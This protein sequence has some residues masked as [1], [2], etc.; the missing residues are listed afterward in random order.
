MI[1]VVAQTK[2]NENNLSF[3]FD[4]IIFYTAAYIF[5]PGKFVAIPYMVIIWGILRKVM[6]LDFELR[7]LLDARYMSARASCTVFNHLRGKTKRVYEVT[8]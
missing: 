8:D 4:A 7:V 2:Q 3:Y 6:L 1:A 5:S